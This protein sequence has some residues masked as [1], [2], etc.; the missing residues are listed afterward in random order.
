M[1]I[2]PFFTAI[3]AIIYVWLSFG[4]IKHRFSKKISM[5]SAGDPA[6]EKAMRIQ[7][8]FGEYVPISLLL[9]WF[10]EVV[11]YSSGLAFILGCVL[12]L[13]RFSHIVGLN[14]SA[15]KLIFRQIG[16]LGTFA[17]ILVSSAVLIWHY[18]PV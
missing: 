6:L 7:G 4:V 3:L 11:T 2:T 9:L 17:V 14:D 10:L 16:T 5:G 18:L 1:P 8:N 12:V 13:S 15:T